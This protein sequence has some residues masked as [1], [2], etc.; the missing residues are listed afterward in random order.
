MNVFADAAGVHCVLGL[1]VDV[2]AGQL[3]RNRLRDLRIAIAE[4]D[5]ETVGD[6]VATG[7]DLDLDV[8]AHHVD[9]AFHRLAAQSFGLVELVLL[10]QRLERTAAGDDLRDTRSTG[11]SGC[12]R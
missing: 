9:D 6:V 5:V 4:A 8:L 2:L 3:R 12:L 7:V 1:V 11:A 10:D